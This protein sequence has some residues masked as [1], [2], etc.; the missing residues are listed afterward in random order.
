MNYRHA[1]HAGNFGD[2]LK[3]VVLIHVLRHMVL[4]PSP[5]RVIDVHAGR[6]LYDLASEE[7][8][9]T[10]EWREGVG[11]FFE[12]GSANEPL[13]E[14]L[15]NYVAV[16]RSFNPAG[17]LSA[18]PGSPAIARAALRVGDTLVANELN[19][20][21]NRALARR[22]AKDAQVRVMAVDAY[23]ALKS[24]LPP[25]E[26]RAVVLIDPPF[27]EAG[28]F[29]RMVKGLGEALRRFKTGVYLLWYPIKD[30][31]PIEKFHRRVR[32]AVAAPVLAV[33]FLLRRANN[34]ERLNGAGML[35]VNP[36]FTLE[37]ALEAAGDVLRRRLTDD[38]AAGFRFQWLVSEQDL[39]AD[40]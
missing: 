13:P 28:E 26:R 12:D 29:D 18:Y 3:H 1:Y 4:K 30:I 19:P 25:K 15:A 16:V 20:E 23:T 8:A 37:P 33:E 38:R 7:A 9:K 21:D 2:V 10:G 32:E 34:P 27:E 31:K 17:G 5:F 11:C 36:P 14:A 35:I 22:F 6:G 24:L 39:N 40:S